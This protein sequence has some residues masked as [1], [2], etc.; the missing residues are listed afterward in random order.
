MMGKATS[1]NTKNKS[2]SIKTIAATKTKTK[3]EVKSTTKINTKVAL[4]TTS[5]NKS[6]NHKIDLAKNII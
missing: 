5:K 4:T 2:T 1:K 3:V 6:T